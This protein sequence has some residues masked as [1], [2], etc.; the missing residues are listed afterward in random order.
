MKRNY[1]HLSIEAL[2]EKRR[3][4]LEYITEQEKTLVD[5]KSMLLQLFLSHCIKTSREDVHMINA[6]LC[7]RGFTGVD[8]V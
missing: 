6:E 4:L 2:L 8:D 3:N 5:T 7:Y 1:Q